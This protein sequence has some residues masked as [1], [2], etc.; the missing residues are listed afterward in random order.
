M[1]SQETAKLG[2]K[3]ETVQAGLALPQPLLPVSS[4]GLG[5]P[6]KRLENSPLSS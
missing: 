4:A 5:L 3:E 6:R 2:K 1:P